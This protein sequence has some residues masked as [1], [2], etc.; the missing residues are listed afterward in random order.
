MRILPTLFLGPPIVT[1]CSGLFTLL[2]SFTTPK[3]YTPWP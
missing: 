2:Q 1:I 3:N